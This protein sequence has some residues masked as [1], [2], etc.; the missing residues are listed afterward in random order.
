[1]TD[2]D[3]VAELLRARG[4]EAIDHPGGTLCAHLERVQHKLADLGASR[5]LQ[6]AGRAHAVYGT[7]GFDVALLTLDERPLLADIAGEDV[8][9]LVYRYGACDRSRTWHGLAET[10]QVWDR[11]TGA[12][13]ALDAE[14]LRDFADLSIVNELDIAEHA[15]EFLAQ[16]S[17][18]IR[19]LTAEWAPLLSPSVAD[20]VR[21][22]L[23]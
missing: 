23:G 5:R 3:R 19:R 20:E 18:F 10:R 16:H 11:F 15:P 17:D 12:C 4:A 2:A 21:R 7:D 1:M 6:L 9:R 22:V 13:E 14:D 8:E